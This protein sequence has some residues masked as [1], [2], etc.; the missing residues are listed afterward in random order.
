M[1][2]I[3]KTLTEIDKYGWKKLRVKRFEERSERDFEKE[4][5]DGQRRW[6]KTNK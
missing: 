1:M 4:E 5:R 2:L 3:M 6:R